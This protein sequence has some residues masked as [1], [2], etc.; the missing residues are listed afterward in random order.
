MASATPELLPPI[1]LAFAASDPTGGAGIQADL[2]TLASMGCHPLSVI[3][4]LTIQDTAGVEEVLAIDAD[5]V[6]DQA[7]A[8]LEDMPVAAFKLGMLGSAETV[9]VIAEIL[10]DYPDIPLVFDPV[11]ASGRGDALADEETIEA[12]IE[13]LLPQTTILTPNSLEVRRLVLDE[14]AEDDD[15]DLPECARRLVA[16]GCEYVLV[17]GTH[18]HTPLVVNTLYGEAGVV[19]SDRWERLPGS[20]HGSGCTL[21]SAIAAN[22]ANGLDMAEAVRDAQDYTWQALA[23]GFRPGMGQFIPD[24]F[25]WARNKGEADEV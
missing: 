13:M 11:L 4:A 2:L 10:A 7:R 6:A 22:L 5:W 12:M 25:F 16:L 23:A 9:S 15:P 18:E 1:V 17:T 14:D 20:F 19:R 24:R 21:A 3:T 8:L